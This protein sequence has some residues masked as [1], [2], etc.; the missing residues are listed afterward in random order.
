M[1]KLFIIH[2]RNLTQ[3]LLML[4]YI[5]MKLQYVFTYWQMT[6]YRDC[7]HC[8]H[9]SYH[10]V[11]FSRSNTF[12]EFLNASLLWHCIVPVHRDKG[13]S[14]NNTL[15]GDLAQVVEFSWNDNSYIILLKRYS[16]ILV[17]EQSAV[18]GQNDQNYFRTNLEHKQSHY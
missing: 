12:S 1:T 2:N 18:V 14:C 10:I 8:V 9:W 13:N 5:V 4:C 17:S 15:Y 3:C 7:Y 16:E 11:T 6:K